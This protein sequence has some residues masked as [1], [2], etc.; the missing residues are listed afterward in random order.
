MNTKTI[1]KI[2]KLYNSGLSFVTVGEKFNLSPTVVRYWLKKANIKSRKGG[3]QKGNALGQINR[4]EIDLKLVIKLYS[5]GLTITEIKERLN[6]PRSI[7]WR[8]LNEAGIQLRKYGYKKRHNSWNKDKIMPLEQRKRQSKTRK[9]LYKEGKLIPS[10]KGKHNKKVIEELFIKV[11]K[12]R[13]QQLTPKKLIKKKNLNPKP[14]IRR[15]TIELLERKRFRNQRYKA[16]K[17]N[18]NGSHN[19]EEWLLLKEYYKNMCLCC[20]QQEPEIKLTEDHIIPL[21]M[22]GTDN[23][24]NIQPL[25]QSCNTRKHA[26][27]VDYRNNSDSL[28]KNQLIIN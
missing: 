20:K 28:I 27:Y 26:K 25:C 11:L 8:R 6:I 21:S 15:T 10:N 1:E 17:R 23:I 16:N 22:G 5:N 9:K 2:V 4:K 7:I 18:A 13:V 24:D 3:F 14:Q 12:K 19:F